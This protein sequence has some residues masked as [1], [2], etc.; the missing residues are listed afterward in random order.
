[1]SENKDNKEKTP[2]SN[3]L[4]DF[5][6]SLFMFVFIDEKSDKVYMRGY[7][8]ESFI[9]SKG[10]N[11]EEQNQFIAYLNK[12]SMYFPIVLWSEAL[13]K[14]MLDKLRKVNLDNGLILTKFLGDIKFMMIVGGKNPP[15][16]NF[17]LSHQMS[18]IPILLRVLD[19]TDHFLEMFENFRKKTAH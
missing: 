14:D 13:P 3:F 11:E 12:A 17:A 16:H 7:D 1:M 18:V 10:L 5:N 2:L 19:N 9:I 4:E 8:T 15:D 6:Y